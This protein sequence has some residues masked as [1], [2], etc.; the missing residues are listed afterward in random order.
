MQKLTKI[1]HPLFGGG[2]IIKSGGGDML[3]IIKNFLRKSLGF[4]YTLAVIG[5]AQ[6]YGLLTKGPRKFFREGPI[7]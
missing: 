3:V 6:F 1:I 2:K 4:L 7:N 5:M